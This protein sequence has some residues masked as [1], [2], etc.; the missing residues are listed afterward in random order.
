MLYQSRS[1]EFLIVQNIAYSKL[2]F[3]FWAW[4]DSVFH[5]HLIL[6]NCVVALF[7]MGG[8]GA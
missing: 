8:G 3:T 7:D 5:L 6:P 2:Y 4:L 1:L